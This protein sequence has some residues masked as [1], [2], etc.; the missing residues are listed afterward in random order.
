MRLQFGDCLFDSGLRVLLR[1]SRPVHLA[2]KAFQLLQLLIEKR[3]R[4][5]AKGELMTALWPEC[6]VT[7]A[8]LANLVSLVRTA[9]GDNARPPRYVR[10]LHGFGYAFVESGNQLPD[11]EPGVEALAALLVEGRE[12]GLLE[13]E[14]L[15][16]RGS[17]CQVRL[18]AV[19]VSRRHA[20]L[21]VLGAEALIEDL[22]SKNGTFVAGERIHGPRRLIDR[23]ELRLGGLQLVYRVSRHDASTVRFRPLPEGPVAP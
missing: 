19:T 20:R 15:L 6:F 11:V 7:E 3:P 18:N 13:G 12:M 22:D 23:D 14:N 4:P 10:T 21:L 5:I 9:L 17:E 8:N 2:P 1:S 16:G